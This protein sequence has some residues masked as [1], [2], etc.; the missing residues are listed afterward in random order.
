MSNDALHWA[1]QQKG[2]NS[3]TKFVLVAMADIV[4]ESNQ[5]FMSVETLSEYTNQNRKTVIKS[6]KILCD[7]GLIEDTGNRKGDTKKIVVYKLNFLNSTETGTIPNTEQFQFFP[8]TVPNFPPNSTVFPSKQSQKRYSDTY[9]NHLEPLT[10]PGEKDLPASITLHESFK[11]FW[12][13][14]PRKVGKEKAKTAWKKIKPDDGLLETILAALAK[15]KKLVDWQKDDGKWIPYPASW[16]NGK[17][18][19]DEITPDN[20]KSQTSEP[21]MGIVG[22]I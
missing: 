20:K 13:A 1:R 7:L 2:I 14:Y 17:R 8:E 12:E 3:A 9:I 21:F 5:F 10:N 18:W 15:Q 11:Q 22:L 4:R 6:L 16:L 19:Q